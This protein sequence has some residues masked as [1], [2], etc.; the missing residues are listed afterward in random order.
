MYDTT[1]QILLQNIKILNTKTI[2][3]KTSLSLF[4]L[5]A[6]YFQKF[7]ADH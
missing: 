2:K 4:I 6:N 7:L 3:K 5:S 1:L